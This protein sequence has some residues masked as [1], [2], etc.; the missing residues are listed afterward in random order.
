MENKQ[1]KY[2]IIIRCYNNEDYIERCILSAINQTYKNFEIIIVDDE[3]NDKSF[4]ICK[5]FADQHSHIKLYKTKHSERTHARNLGLKKSSGNYIIYLDGDDW[6]DINSLEFCDEI[7]KENDSKPEMIVFKWREIS[8]DNINAEFNDK[9]NKVLGVMRSHDYIKNNVQEFIPN[10]DL[11]VSFF[12][13]NLLINHYC[14]DES[15]IICEDNAYT[16]ESLYNAKYVYFSNNTIYNYNR[17]RY[18]GQNR[19]V[20]KGLEEFSKLGNYVFNNLG[21]QYTD[22]KLHKQLT[23]WFYDYFWNRMPEFLKEHDWNIKNASKAIIRNNNLELDKLVK[24]F[25]PYDGIKFR[26]KLSWFLIRHKMYKTYFFIYKLKNG[27]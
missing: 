17:L 14:K 4:S 8:E 9:N 21:K 25:I 16:Y 26:D 13:R 11:T 15:I 19:K 1:T 23:K 7:L 10:A 24:N 3:S 27:K 2:S 12:R 6:L 5:E 22:E 18:F 20:N